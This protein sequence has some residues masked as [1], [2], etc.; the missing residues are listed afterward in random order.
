MVGYLTS[1]R[2]CDWSGASSG[3]VVLETETSG[4]IDFYYHYIVYDVS[5][6]DLRCFLCFVRILEFKYGLHL[7]EVQ[8]VGS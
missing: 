4:T 1:K 3:L 6:T 2:G 7:R 5:L 8:L